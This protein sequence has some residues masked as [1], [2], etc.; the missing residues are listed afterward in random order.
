MQCFLLVQ[1]FSSFTREYWMKNL[2]TCLT[3]S[4]IRKEMSQGT[5]QLVFFINDTAQLG[6]AQRFVINGIS[7]E[8]VVG[9]G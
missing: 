3:L 1:V 6:I 9:W 8:N 7:K 4:L 5:W 2:K